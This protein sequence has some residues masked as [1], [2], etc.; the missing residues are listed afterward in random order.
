MTRPPVTVPRWRVTDDEAGSRLDKFLASPNRLS[1][2]SRMSLARTT[3]ERWRFPAMPC[4]RIGLPSYIRRTGDRCGS[5]P[6]F[7]TT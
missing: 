5:K 6:R 1:S 4:T 3:S 2:R 7:L